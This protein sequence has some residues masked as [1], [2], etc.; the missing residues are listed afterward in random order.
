MELIEANT[1]VPD[2][3]LGDIMANV[4]CTELSARQ[5]LEF[6]DE[7]GIDDLAAL[8]AAIRAQSEQAVRQGISRMRD[9]PV[10]Q[11]DLHRGNRRA[12]RAGLSDRRA[13]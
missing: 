9:G 7:Y 3:V 2:Q 11:R 4:T 1:R 12:G 6:M 8:S 13:G 5:L 10:C